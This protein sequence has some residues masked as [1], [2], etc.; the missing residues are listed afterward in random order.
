MKRFEIGD[1]EKSILVPRRWV[2][3]QEDE[4]TVLLYDPHMKDIQVRISV[5]SLKSASIREPGRVWVEQ[6]ANERALRPVTSEDMVYI[7][8][9]EKPEITGQAPERYFEVGFRNHYILFTITPKLPIWEER[10]IRRTVDEVREMII[11]IEERPD[12][13]QWV[14]E[15][16][17]NDIKFL[18]G[19]IQLVDRELQRLGLPT[20]DIYALDQLMERKPW[21]IDDTE[22][23]QA[24]GLKLGLL[25]RNEI[26]G[27]HWVIVKDDDGRDPALR[28]SKTS[29]LVYPRAMLAKR[30]QTREEFTAA[31]LFDQVIET[32]EVMVRQGY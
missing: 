12:G 14:L 8:H 23:W 29:V 6:K 10:I 21:R 2:A 11:S 15:P 18:N 19:Q 25:L 4:E 30:L 17:Q 32:V 31:S 24:A 1:G 22:F 7:T 28:Y 20:D 16:Q 5:L 13:E 27:F 3:E 26:S 9:E